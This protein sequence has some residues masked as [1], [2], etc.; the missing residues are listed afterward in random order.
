MVARTGA[1]R[2]PADRAVTERFVEVPGG[3]LFTRSLVEGERVIALHGGPGIVD[4]TYL[5]P[6]MDRLVEDLGGVCDALELDVV[7]LLGHSWG[8]HLA[9][10]LAIER[11]VR[12][13]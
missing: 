6:E 2:R 1:G 13:G 12:R 10:Q 11:R 4:H 7:T 3:G 9:L 5:L 8:T